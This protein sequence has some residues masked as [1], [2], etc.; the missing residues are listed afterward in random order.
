MSS[1]TSQV[2]KVIKPHLP[3]IKFKKGIV[4][5]THDTKESVSS[6]KS[7]GSTVKG[8]GIDESLLPKRYQRKRMTALEM[9][10]IE[11]GGSETL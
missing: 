6:V 8:S 1:N 4:V 2:W 9:E 3:L 5:K 10:I 11:R 7:I